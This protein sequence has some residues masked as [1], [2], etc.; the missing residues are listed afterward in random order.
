MVAVG[1]LVQVQVHQQAR[2]ALGHPAHQR[3]GFLDLAAVT[4]A[5]VRVDGIRVPALDALVAPRTD[6]RRHDQVQPAQV[7][8]GLL[9]QELQGAMHDAGLVAMHAAGDQRGRQC[10]V[11]VMVDHREQRIVVRGVVQLAVL[12]HI[13]DAV[14]QALEGG[15]HI[16]VGCPG[17]PIG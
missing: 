17:V 4:E 11:P 16:V 14:I 9:F 12:D 2:L 6:A 10:R 3:G 1:G 7:T 5:A 8:L 15:H 13:E